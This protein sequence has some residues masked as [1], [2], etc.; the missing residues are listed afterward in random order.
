MT[1]EINDKLT[2][3]EESLKAN[4]NAVVVRECGSLF[5][6]VLKRMFRELLT[7]LP[8]EKRRVFIEVE[9]TIGKGK[10]GFE[11]FTLGEM[12]GLE[13]QVKL[14]NNWSEYTN[15]NIGLLTSFDLASIVALRNKCVH[16]TDIEDDREIVSNLEANLVYNYLKNLLA[17]IGMIDFNKEVPLKKDSPEYQNKKDTNNVVYEN[18]ESVND[19]YPIL[20]K[21]INKFINEGTKIEILN[22]GLDLETVWPRLLINIINNRE[23]DNITYKGLLINP[24]SEKI[25]Q[26]CDVYI[27]PSTASQVMKKLNTTIKKN[28]EY[29]VDRNIQIEFKTYDD[30]PIIHGFSINNRYLFFSLTSFED[31]ELTGGFGGYGYYESGK[32]GKTFEYFLESFKNWFDYYWNL[33]INNQ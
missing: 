11:K 32:S 9:N 6:Q 15:T 26:Y 5:E 14:L 3:I 4:R 7:G 8:F 33:E 22:F 18:I 30:L 17:V 1:A 24:L 29:L 10:K 27:S 21:I 28:K 25:N 19:V 31:G 23:W 20:I 13:R 12:V 16:A 2:F